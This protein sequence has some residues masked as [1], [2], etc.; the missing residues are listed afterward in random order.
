M[1]P[2]ISAPI[3]PGPL[4]HYA[5]HGCTQLSSWPKMKSLIVIWAS[6][7]THLTRSK[8]F[9]FFSRQRAEAKQ[10]S[11]EESST[12]AEHRASQMRRSRCT[13]QG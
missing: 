13:R 9:F 1:A 12:A 6:L 11:R 5:L 2:P 4:F 8:C 10:K 7:I 3:A